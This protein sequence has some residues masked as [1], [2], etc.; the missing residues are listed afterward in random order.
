LASLKDFSNNVFGQARTFWG[1]LNLSKRIT[2]GA[3]V[4]TIVGL[5]SAVMIMSQREPFEYLFVD[6][7]PTDK[8][9]IAAYLNANGVNDYVIDQ[10]G[11]KVP[12][13][14]VL[15]L[16]IELAQRGIP[17]Q[18][19]VG[20]EQF[21]KQDFARTEFEQNIN[22]KRALEGELTRTI[23]AIDGILSSRVHITA[24]DR[25]IF[26]RDEK[27]R[28]AAVYLK[29]RQGFEL[30]KAQIR[31]I[32]HLVSGSV[33]GLK[34]KSITIIDAEGNMLT[35][36]EE[37][38]ENA[39]LTKERLIYRK[40]V[41]QRYEEKIRAIVGRIVGPDRVDAKV[42]AE[43]DFNQ[44]VQKI[45]DVD[46]DQVA[47]ESKRTKGM[48]MKG[49]GLNPTG[50]PG[51]KSN[52][53]SEQEPVNTAS[54]G[55]GTDSSN[56]EETVN[57]QVSKKVSERTLAAGNT[58]RMT[59]AVIVDGRQIYP[60]DGSVP[61]FV[62]RTPEEMKKIEE[63][64][65][66]TIGFRDERDTVTVHNMMFQLNPFQVQKLTEKKE[67]N[68]RYISTLVLSSTIAIALAL[69]FAF[70]VRPYFR[71]LS[72]DPQR[73][74][75]QGRIED[76]KPD[77]ELASVQNVQ[78]QEDVPFDK[79]TPQEQ[80]I[81]LARHEPKRTTEAIRMLLNPHQSNPL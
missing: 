28:T 63:L 58:M 25:S 20:W 54:G 60:V 22:K 38:D 14:R 81:Y 9:E 48:K 62:E 11:I 70:I 16:R 39:R 24:P 30:D 2:L 42:D 79:L 8:Q 13:G 37:S 59:A 3:V 50:I 78:V 41:E 73:K 21:D 31:G 64:V 29:T 53:P 75:S 6:L 5:M 74:S 66:S 51:A 4:V 72:Y 65:K 44:E 69:F 55:M 10:K 77:L 43:I 45:S 26:V 18:G 23:N 61:E 7:S 12:P 35:E 47:V 27:D 1:S 19:Q 36:I 49:T 46:P 32:Q 56:E 57:Y 68:R 52:V 33:E 76:F 34:P 40:S 67:E 17:T 15:K 80:V 71:W